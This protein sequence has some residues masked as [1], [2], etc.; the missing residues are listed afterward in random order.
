MDITFDTLAYSAILQDSGVPREQADAMAKANASALRDMIKSQELATKQDIE[1]ALAKMRNDIDKSISQNT[2]NIIKW[3]MGMIVAQ[4]T[5]T[6]TAFAI[7]LSL[8]K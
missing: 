8:V 5:L 2:Q 1:L 6:L 4:T 7:G 3:V